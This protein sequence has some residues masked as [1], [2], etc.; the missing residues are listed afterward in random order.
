ML[1]KTV[2]RSIILGT[3]V[4]TVCATS[5]LAHSGM[6]KSGFLAGAQIGASFGNGKFNSTLSINPAL[7]NNSSSPSGSA[8]KTAA[9]FGILGGYRHIFN[10]DYTV[11]FNLEANFFANNQLSKQLAFTNGVPNPLVN[12]IL[13]KTFTV[14]PSVALGKIFC[15]R[16]HTSVGLG[17]AISRFKQEY[18]ILNPIIN[19]GQTGSST[20]TK[21]GIVPMVGVE[22]ATTQNV[23]VFANVGYEFYGKLSRKNTLDIV[24]AN[25]SSYSQSIKPNYWNLKLGAV[26]RF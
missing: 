25:P 7:P 19:A 23:S 21:V 18:K 24:G 11:A 20:R 4:T 6:Y 13:K 1:K 3:I 22:Y 14:M 5:T 12:N 9:L 15:G 26:Y 16:W 10:Q 17:L 8:R 2:T